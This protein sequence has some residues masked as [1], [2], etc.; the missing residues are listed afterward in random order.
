MSIRLTDIHVAASFE[1]AKVPVLKRLSL[2]VPDG[3]RVGVLGLPKSGKTTLLRAIC[4]TLD[5]DQGKVE[6]TSRTSWPIPQMAFF[7]NSSSVACNIRFLARLYGIA[8]KTFPRRI[9][10]LSGVEEFL[11]AELQSCPR[12][13]KSRLAFGLG[14]GL[15]F[16]TYLFDGSLTPCDKDFKARATEIVGER[17]KGCGYVVASAN[18]KE[19]EKV[20]DSVYV[21]EAG[22]ARYFDAMAEGTEYFKQLLTAAPKQEEA[23]DKE[24]KEDAA[25]EEETDGPG[26]MDIIVAAVMDE[27]E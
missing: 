12:F 16:D 14:I 1:G 25:I 6:R 2:E 27:L 17:L 10:E 24:S 26:D 20:C 4:G 15:D 9:A 18:P 21:L 3:G 23:A 5:L 11:N 19:V 7:N 8:D 22:E 13:V